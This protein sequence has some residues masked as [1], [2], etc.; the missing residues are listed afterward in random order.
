MAPGARCTL[1]MLLCLL[2]SGPAAAA[3]ALLLF[4]GRNH[5]EFMGCL[6]CGN[7]DPESVC[8]AYGDYGSLYG[9]RS[10]W[11]KDGAYGSPHSARSPWNRHADQA[12][13]IADKDGGVYGF[14]TANPR[15]PFRTGIAHLVFMLDHPEVVV[16]DM[17]K[18]REWLCAD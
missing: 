12:P 17:P 15:Q 9:R 7:H 11:N 2:L 13:V 5:D 16:S 3:E 18:A 8:N 1:G 14:F 10:I 6:N 4:G